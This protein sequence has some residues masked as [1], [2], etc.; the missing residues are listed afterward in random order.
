MSSILLLIRGNHHEKAQDLK[1]N[2][3]V[4]EGQSIRLEELMTWMES[5]LTITSPSITLA[6]PMSQLIRSQNNLLRRKERERRLVRKPVHGLFKKSPAHLDYPSSGVYEGPI[7]E[8]GRAHDVDGEPLDHH[9]SSITLAD[10]MSQLK[11]HRTN[12]MRRKIERA[13]TWSWKPSSRSFQEEPSSSDYP[14]SGVYEGPS[15]RLEEL[16]TSG[17][18]EGHI[19]K[20]GRAHDTRVTGLFKKSPAH[21]DYPSSGVYEGHIDKTGRAHDIDEPTGKPLSIP[22]ARLM[23]SIL[24]LISGK[25]SRRKPKIE[26]KSNW[27]VQK[28]P[29]HS[30]IPA[31]ESTKDISIR[32]EELMTWM[33]SLLTI[34]SPSITLADPMSHGKAPEHTK[35]KTH[36]QHPSLFLTIPAPESTKDPSMRLEELMTWMESLDH[37]V[38]VYHSGRS[39]EPTGKAPEQTK[40]KTHEQHPSVD[41]GET[42]TEKA[43]DLKTRVTGL[44]KKSPAHLDYPSS[45]V[46]EGHI[47]KTGRAHDVDG[48]PLD[49]HVSVYHSGRSDEPTGKAPEQTKIKTH[50]QH[51]SSNWPLQEDPAHLDYPSSGVYEGHID[52]TGRAHDVDGEPLDHHVSVYHSGRSDEPTGKAPE[53]TKSKTHEQHPSTRVTGLFKKSPAHLDYPSSGVYEG[54]I[55]KTGRAHDVD[56]EPLDHHVSVYHSGRSDEPTG[57][58]PE[59]TKTRLITA[60]F[61]K[62]NWLVQKEPAHLDYPSSGVYEGH[63]DKT[64]R[65]HDVD[66]E[67]LDHHVSVYHSGRSDEPT[68]KAPE[69]TKIKTHEQHPSTRVT[70]LF[71]KNP[72]HLDYP[73][74][75][76]YEGHIDKTGRAHDVDGEPLDHHVSVY[77]SGRSDEPTGKAP[78]HTKSKTHEQ[79]PS[80]DL[81]ETIT[82][83]AQ[84]LKTRLIDYPSSGVYEGHIDKTGRAHD[85]DGEPLDHHVSVYHSGRSDEPTGKAPEHTKIKTHE[86]HPSV[87][88]GETITRKI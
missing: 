45:G 15:M 73:S 56:G 9:V 8:T 1:T 51:P 10:P 6:D 85:V 57:K 28:S 69:Q 68:G 21:L 81:G 14:S 77:H 19:D 29:A 83:K 27:L 13:W 78:E 11:D 87:D 67:P 50:E 31:P 72:A 25:P 62:S 76:V 58:A 55:D 7:D 88:L 36:E 32:L 74:S 48:E 35:S 65:A 20:T 63:I 38:S 75:G 30:T 23:S 41:L 22:K 44:F 54:H 17:V 49:H 79:H 43:Q 84:D 46:Y 42:I 60:S 52:K 3:G 71:K 2:S 64:G 47:D 34:T 16:M 26:D 33:E 61:Y 18:Y 53:H 59:H 82:E 37:H 39:D 12:T 70:G 86:Q 4:Y 24:L 66:G 5:L 40:I 80:V